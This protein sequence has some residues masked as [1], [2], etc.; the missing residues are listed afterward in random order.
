M[1]VYYMHTVP[2]EARRGQQIRL[3]WS[4]V[5]RLVSSLVGAGNYILV[6]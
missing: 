1:S 6:F 4:Y 5:A 2:E 3:I